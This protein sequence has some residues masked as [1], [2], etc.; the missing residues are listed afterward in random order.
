MENTRSKDFRYVYAGGFSMLFN[1]QDAIIRFGVKVD[2]SLD[3]LHEEV[4]VIMSPSTM[5]LLGKLL[6]RMAEMVE[7][8]TGQEIP[9]DPSKLAAIE[10]SIQSAEQAQ[11][12]KVE[13]V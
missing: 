7:T 6:V 11:R 8:A 3:I 1:G 4:G 9:V 2:G 10:Q 13:P 5:K 12:S